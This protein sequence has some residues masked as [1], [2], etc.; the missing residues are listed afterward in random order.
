M[1]H[2]WYKD[3]GEHGNGLLW[4]L[5]SADSCDMRT[6]QTGWSLA[7]AGYEQPQSW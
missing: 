4:F 2:P 6:K 7:G 1:R 5:H 3:G